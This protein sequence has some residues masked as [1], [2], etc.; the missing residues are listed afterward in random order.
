M[1]AGLPDPSGAAQVQRCTETDTRGSTRERSIPGPSV[2]LTEIGFGASVIG[3]L[4]RAT[5]DDEAA[6]AVAAAWDADLRA[7]GL[8]S[9]D[10]PTAAGRVRCH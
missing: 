4:Y 3:N 7:R 2:A 9:P 5:T 6:A 10:V 8:I 1:T